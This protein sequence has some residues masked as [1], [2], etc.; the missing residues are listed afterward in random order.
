MAQ[1]AATT[2]TEAPA[3]DEGE[4]IVTG[5]ILRRNDIDT[6]SPITVLSAENLDRRAQTSTQEAIQNLASNNGPAL[7]NSFSANGAFAGGASAVSLRGLSTNSTLVLFDGLRA[8]YYPLADDG[9]RN[10]VDLNTIPDDI[11][12]E[13]EVLRDG[14]SSS[15]GADAIAG[16]VNIKTRRQFSGV[17]GRAEAGISSRGDA[18]NQRLSLM[19]GKGDIASDGFNVYASG[20]Y[21]HSAALYNRDRGY[22]YNSDDQRNICFNGNCG[23]NNVVNG[24]NGDGAFPDNGFNTALATFFVRPYDATNTTAQG[25]NQ[26]LNP[27]AGCRAGTAYNPTAAEL[28]LP[29]NGSVPT[30]VCQEDI[31]NLYG[32]IAPEI[33]RFGGSLKATVSVGDNSEAYALFNFVQSNVSYSG[34]PTT[35]RGNAAPPFFFPRYSTSAPSVAY[36]NSVLTLPVFVCPRGTTAPCTAANGTLNPNNPFAAQGQV[37]RLSGRLSDSREYDETRSRVYRVAAGIKGTVFNNWDYSVDVTAMHN[38]LRHEYRGYA[39]IQHLLDVIADGSY[40]FVNP[41]L[42]SQAVRDYVTPVNINNSTSDLYQAQFS[43]GKS[44]F[45]L[46]GGPLQIGF[47]AAIRYEAVDAPSA[48]SDINGP[49]ERYFRINGFGVKGHRTV[50]SAYGEVNAPVLDSVELNVSGRY[51]KYSSG[52]SNFSPKFGATFTPIKQVL[53][54][55]TYSRGF[56]IPSFGEANA[57]FP[58]TGFVGNSA[59]T[60]NDAYLAQYGCTV[61]T[62]DDDCPTYLSTGSYG[63]TNLSN[64]N[65]RPEKSRSFTGGVVFK[66]TRNLTFSVDYYNIKKTDVITT[67]SVTPALKAYYAGQPIPAGFTVTPDGVDPDFTTA[68]PRVAFVGAQF[69]NANT[70]K[71]EG[72]DFAANL[73]LPLSDRISWTSNIEA[74][75][76]IELSTTFPDGSKESYA[77]TLGNFNLTAGSGTPR[78]HANWQNTLSFDDKFTLT[79]TVNYFD[80]YK[81]TAED[82]FGPGSRNDCSGFDIDYTPCKVRRYITLDLV[83][84]VKVGD[85]F[86][87]Y[88]N[89]LNVLNDLPPIDAVTYGAHLY[90]PIQGGTGIIGRSFRAG[91]KVGF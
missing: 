67:A 25:R 70:Q 16:V 35:I 22:P 14:A 2:A 8:A 5:S 56:R 43:L 52:Q 66:P 76:I 63:S 90:N 77:G 62:F 51:D 41:E 55:G 1:E 20:F 9:T 27:A 4:I 38:E 46:P 53:L 31:T 45:D 29:N 58:T 60:F 3:A 40:N 83:G 50:Y 74:S 18:A 10:F 61:A 91:V 73:N 64:P 19:V 36:G 17:A 88:A 68:I 47:G 33:T 26:F 69:I 65:L 32:V 39:Y 54:R 87:L 42:N 79:G 85:N 21:N 49:T 11:I 59:G 12:Q 28:A 13:I 37:A 44:L 6:P 71:S 15:Y 30:T 80:S 86:T 78:W 23:P 72:L 7:T 81:L 34:I 89:V 82:Q 48:N 57:T 84:T 75:Y 24:L